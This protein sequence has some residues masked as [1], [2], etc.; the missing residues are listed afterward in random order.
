M[1]TIG[2]SNPHAVAEQPCIS[3]RLRGERRRSEADAHDASAIEIPDEVPASDPRRTK[4]LERRCSAPADADVRPFDE[5]DRGIEDHL[6]DGT[7]VG[8]R[9]DPF[10]PGLVV[11]AVPVIAPHRDHRQ[12]GSDLVL[13]IEHQRQFAERHAGTQRHWKIPGKRAQ[14]RI[15]DR[16]F[17]D[18]GVDRI[19]PVEH[20]DCDVLARRRLQQIRHGRR[21]REKADSSVLQIDDYGI[22]PCQHRA[23]RPQGCPVKRAHRKPC[24][25]INPRRDPAFAIGVQSMLRRENPLEL[26]ARR[27]G[28]NV[29]RTRSGEIAPGAVGE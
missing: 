19:R 27:G 26:H 12:L 29:N 20:I 25:C 18:R 13:A 3:V 11:P 8:R 22:E 9:G 2:D 16:A 1:P 21:I 5:T 28:Q 14:R 15:E 24:G 17:D 10:E 4:P 7:E 23:P 6:G